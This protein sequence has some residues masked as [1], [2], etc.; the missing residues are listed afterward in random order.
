MNSSFDR[1]SVRRSL[2]QSLE[3]CEVRTLTAVNGMNNITDLK[4]DQVETSVMPGRK[5]S[6]AEVKTKTSTLEKNANITGVLTIKNFSFI[7]DKKIQLTMDSEMEK[8]VVER[9]HSVPVLVSPLKKLVRTFSDVPGCTLLDVGRPLGTQVIPYFRRQTMPMH[10]R[11]MSTQISKSCVKPFDEWSYSTYRGKHYGTCYSKKKSSREHKQHPQKYGHTQKCM[12]SKTPHTKKPKTR[13]S[14][15]AEPSHS[16]T[17]PPDADNDVIIIENNVKENVD[18]VDSGSRQSVTSSS[19]ND[20]KRE[21]EYTRF[22]HHHVSRGEPGFNFTVMSY[23]ILAQNLLEDNSYLYENCDDDFLN[24]EYRQQKL[25]G[26]ISRFRPDIL[27]MQEVYKDHYESFFK[28]KLQHLGYSGEYIKRSGDKQDGCATFYVNSKFT[29]DHVTPVPYFCDKNSVLDRDNVGLVLSLKPLKE[30]YSGERICVGNTHLLYN[31]RRGD[32]KLAQL[33]MLFAE[34]DQ[35]SYK[36]GTNSNINNYQYHPVILCGDLN[37]EPY[38]HLYRLIAKGYLY[39]EGLCSHIISGQRGDRQRKPHYLERDFFPSK[40]SIS[41]QC[42]YIH[43]VLKRHGVDPK[44]VDMRSP[45]PFYTQGSGYL[46]HRLNLMSAYTHRIQRLNNREAE[47]TTHHG[48][49]D[50]TVDYIFYNVLDKH[51]Q[52]TR[53][54]LVAQNIREGKLKLVGRLGLM[55]EK[56]LRRMGGMPNKFFPS[57]HLSLMAKFNLSDY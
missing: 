21:W 3:E 44:M 45:C 41:D 25:L 20:F 31:P 26:E 51:M 53:H 15:D 14:L 23:N 10:Y 17:K 22:G 48:R 7:N 37:S 4:L 42:Q 5:D 18:H 24:W 29:P 36:S 55:S 12:S 35:C 2:Q 27:C 49:A 50:C 6:A 54:E 56:E 1:F 43:T 30:K 38:S 13:L 32:V 28:P 16:A 8:S 9:N 34:L 19:K 57:D 47:V 46:W 40:L 39:Y 33:M 11:H 52:E